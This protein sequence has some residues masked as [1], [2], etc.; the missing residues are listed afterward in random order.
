MFAGGELFRG[1]TPT[2]GSVAIAGVHLDGPA[3][4]FWAPI[5]D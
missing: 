1:F 2:R 4:L 3:L 5:S